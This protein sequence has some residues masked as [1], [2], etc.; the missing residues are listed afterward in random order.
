[1]VED[2]QLPLL[3]VVTRSA[4]GEGA[5][6]DRRPHAPGDDRHIPPELVLRVL[7]RI[8]RVLIAPFVRLEI[9]GGACADKLT[10]GVIVANHRSMADAVVG[11]VVLH[12]F[13]HYPRVLIAREYVE[14][15]W[16]GVF[17]RAGGSIPVE[18]GGD[19]ERV[20]DTAV[21]TLEAGVPILVMPEGRLH[22]D[23]DDPNTTGPARTGAARLA[24]RS[25]MPVVAAALSGTA[26][27]WP[28]DRMLP[29]LNPFRRRVVLCRVADDPFYVPGEDA[30]ED[31]GVVMAELRALLRR[32]NEERAALATR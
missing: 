7:A 12:H 29:R 14:A 25:N 6:T 18:R 4:G 17:A 11:L 28:P 15:R 32:A 31:T 1:M 20:L 10:T 2:R 27:A 16:T 24:A 19:P 26:A 23:D 30:Q 5:E 13:G 8:L 9:R 3:H 21:E 22:R